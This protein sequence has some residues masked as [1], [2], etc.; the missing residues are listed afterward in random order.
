M[1]L[2]D[3]Q[4]NIIEHLIP[5]ARKG[6]NGS[7]RPAKPARDILNGILWILRTGAP[8]HDL[9]KRFPSYQ[10]CHRRFQ[11]WVDNGVLLNILIALRLDL[12]ER[13]GIDD[14]EGYIDG[15]YIP[16]KKGVKKSV[17]AAAERPQSSWRWQT[18]MVFHSLLLLQTET[19]TTVCSPTQ[20]LT[21]LSSMN[22]PENSL[23]T[24][25]GTALNIRKPLPKRETSS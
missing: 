24:K 16:A 23:P 13:G 11:A 7:G 15:T 5:E 6:P 12:K 8:W 20:L 19:D 22:F 9:P 14:I 4:W 25:P 2:T 1:N 18:A 10:T 21:L 17:E 3:K